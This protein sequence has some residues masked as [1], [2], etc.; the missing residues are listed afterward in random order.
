[1]LIHQVLKTALTD[2]NY[3]LSESSEDQPSSIYSKAPGPKVGYAWVADLRPH[4]GLVVLWPN[5]VRTRKDESIKFSQSDPTLIVQ[6]VAALDN[7]RDN[8]S[9]NYW[10]EE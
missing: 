7:I 6:I 5:W 9:L 1:M 10:F 8:G 4:D 3:V 2:H